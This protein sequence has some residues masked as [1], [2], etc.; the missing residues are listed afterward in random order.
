MFFCNSGQSRD[1][2]MTTEILFGKKTDTSNYDSEMMTSWVARMVTKK[3]QWS[4]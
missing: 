2:V 3:V 1:L 4:D